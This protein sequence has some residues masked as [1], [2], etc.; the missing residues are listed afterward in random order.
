ML[1]LPTFVE[2]KDS[3]KV[4][5]NFQVHKYPEFFTIFKTLNEFLISMRVGNTK[6]TKKC[7]M[8]HAKTLYDLE[9]Y[10]NIDDIYNAKEIGF[11]RK[12]SR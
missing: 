9:N 4:L 12:L 11:L 8:E 5:K 7:Q 3:L 2:V 10:K 1:S 6:H